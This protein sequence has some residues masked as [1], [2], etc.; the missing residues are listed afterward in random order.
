MS[1]EQKW[2][3][4]KLEALPGYTDHQLGQVVA[5]NIHD[6]QIEKGDMILVE[7]KTK[8]EVDQIMRELQ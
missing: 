6:H 5:F 1:N 4:V 8:E 7:L 3:T 2:E